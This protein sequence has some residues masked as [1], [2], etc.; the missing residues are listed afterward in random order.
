MTRRVLRTP[1]DG[2][3]DPTNILAVPFRP[4]PKGSER[5]SPL[6]RQIRFALNSLDGC[7]FWRN[8][9]GEGTIVR[10]GGRKEYVRYGLSPGSPDLVGYIVAGGRALFAG[11]EV[12]GAR[13]T[14][15]EE[16]RLWHGVVTRDGGLVVVARSVEAAVAWVKA[17]Q[18]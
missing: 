18:S 1:P 9:V 14:V 12:K 3:A 13:G 4:D 2:V 11:V 6:M 7:R 5:E 16:Q 8:D 17:V 15:S 10:S